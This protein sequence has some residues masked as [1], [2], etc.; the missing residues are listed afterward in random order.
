MIPKDT[1]SRPS[2]ARTGN[3]SPAKACAPSAQDR[4][5]TPRNRVDLRKITEAIGQ[6]K[7]DV[8]AVMD[9]CRCGDVGP[10]FDCRRFKQAN[11]DNS[12]QHIH[13]RDRAEHQRPVVGGL[14]DGVPQRVQNRRA[15]NKRKG[16]P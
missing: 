8:I 16:E 12:D 7:E 2:Q 3:V 10:A 1:D 5:E 11:Q 15:K 6:K 9:Q 13:C 14:D 4:R